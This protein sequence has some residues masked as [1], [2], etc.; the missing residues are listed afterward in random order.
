MSTNRLHWLLFT[1]VLSGITLFTFLTVQPGHDWGDDFAQYIRLAANIADG[2]PYR[3]TGYI[4]NPDNPGIGPDAYPPIFPLILA[5]VVALL[6]V[7][8]VAF[9]YVEC[10]FLLG[11]LVAFY[12][13]F[14]PK[15]G[16]PASLTAM[17]I[18]GLH[19]VINSLKNQVLS[20][21]PFLFFLLAAFWIV[22]Q[23]LIQ[24]KPRQW[25]QIGLAGLIMYACIGLRSIGLVLLPA[26]IF[27]EW[28]ASRKFP[29]TALAMSFIAGL[30]IVAQSMILPTNS[31]YLGMFVLDPGIWLRNF[32][33]YAFGLLVI[34]NMNWGLVGSGLVMAVIFFFFLIG[35]WTQLKTKPTLTD[36]FFVAYFLALVIWPF[37][38]GIR[39]LLPLL[40]LSV[41]YI[42]RGI[43]KVSQ[44]LNHPIGTKFMLIFPSILL[45]A[46]YASNFRMVSYAPQ[47]IGV[48]STDAKALFLEIRQKTSDNDVLIFFK[49][50]ALALFTDRKASGFAVYTEDSRF[51]WWIDQIEAKYLIAELFES[52]YNFRDGQLEFYADQ[53]ARRHPER[54]QLVYTNPSFNIYAILPV[55]H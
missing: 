4:I 2:K 52:E 47:D 17:A 43:E 48:E 35:F 40:F 20:D 45:L 18:L 22:N 28:S 42:F 25:W 50:R 55:N 46:G 38:Q 39:F 24:K 12:F 26:V 15:L 23:I 13:L 11:S 21:L 37:F 41:F 33:S 3:E 34:W 5:P 16:F 31:Q 14:Q 53:F 8:L 54:F 36:Y 6:G 29:A 51:L 44:R 10:L 9:K 7:N 19:P 27:A 49:P 32:G 30:L 1:L